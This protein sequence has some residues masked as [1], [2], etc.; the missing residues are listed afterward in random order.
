MY[1]LCLY[2]HTH[3]HTH[4]HARAHAHNYFHYILTQRA[5][6]CGLVYVIWAVHKPLAI[7]L[8]EDSIKVQK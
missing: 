4:T 5:M 3:T 7:A 6:E 1:L 8:D 2:I